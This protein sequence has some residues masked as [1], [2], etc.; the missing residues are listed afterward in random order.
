VRDAAHAHELG[1]DGWAA[2]A[3]EFVELLEGT[4]TGA[5]TTSN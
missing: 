2:S 1:A 4:P 5:V 3:R